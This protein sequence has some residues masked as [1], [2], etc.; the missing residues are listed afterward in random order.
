MTDKAIRYQLEAAFDQALRHYYKFCK[1]ERTCELDDRVYKK[2]D[3]R[4]FHSLSLEAGRVFALVEL[5]P[6]LS[7]RADL[8][9]I[10]Q[11]AR[12]DAHGVWREKVFKDFLPQP[13][14]EAKAA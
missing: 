8:S 12:E 14:E 5:C 4:G 7:D 3:G 2:Y 6:E 11:D 9:R 1:A 13:D 10:R